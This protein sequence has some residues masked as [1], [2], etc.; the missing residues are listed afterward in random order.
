MTSFLEIQSPSATTIEFKVSSKE[1]GRSVTAT[2][3][4]HVVR[5]FTIVLLLLFNV[6]KAQQSNLIDRSISDAFS[7]LVWLDP[8]FGW[9]AAITDWRVFIPLNFTVFFLCLRRDYTGMY[10]LAK[11]FGGF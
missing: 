9:L 7:P 11:R 8:L 3:L 6:V 4:R 1:P 2:V 5:T 10:N